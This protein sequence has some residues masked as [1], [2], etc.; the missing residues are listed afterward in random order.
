MYRHLEEYCRDRDAQDGEATHL[1]FVWHG[2]EPMMQPPQY[3]RDTFAD[4]EEILG[5]RSLRNT[6]QT[7]LMLLDEERMRL[8][9]DGFDKVGVSVDVVGG[10]RV[11]IA[12]RDSQAQVI[13]NL[14]RLKA[15]RR[16]GCITVLT[17]RNLSA[18]EEIFRFFEE[19]GA[20]SRVLPLFDTGEEEQTRGLE[21]TQQQ[22]LA[23]LAR[24]TELWLKSDR[25][26]QPPAPLDEY[27]AVAA[28][29]LAGIPGPV[30][31]D[32]RE[33]RYGTRLG[34]KRRLSRSLRATVRGTAHD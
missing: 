24:L 6:V 30:Y 23:A 28:R 9:A 33:W 7:N 19:L 29:H 20:G 34:G 12:G 2:G 18:I 14:R 17:A 10:L 3:F 5:Q 8:L 21:I 11:N 22:Q 4:Q 16:V 1:E 31:R 25:M 26:Q 13:A 32:R 15:V 27:V